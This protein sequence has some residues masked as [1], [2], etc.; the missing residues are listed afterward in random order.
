M[1]F[2]PYQAERLRVSL[3]RLGVSF[4][5]KPM[6]GGL[7]F[8]V[9][10]KMCLGTHIDKSSS[11]NLL[12]LRIGADNVLSNLSRLGAMPMDFTGRPMKDYLFVSEEGFDTDEDLEYW[13]QLALAFNPLAKA[14]KK[15]R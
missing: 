11:K 1:A 5:E 15:K 12:M 8:M 13:L 4:I 6:I 14:S 2:D 7:C 3:I 9:D 10:D